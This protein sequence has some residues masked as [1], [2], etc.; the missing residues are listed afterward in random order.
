[1]D[2]MIAAAEAIHTRDPQ[3]RYF[4]HVAMAGEYVR[5][6]RHLLGSGTL[7]AGRTTPGN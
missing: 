5:M 4:T 1:M 2:E 7:P 3:A 6:Y